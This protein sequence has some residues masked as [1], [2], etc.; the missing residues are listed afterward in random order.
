MSRDRSNGNARIVLGLTV[1]AVGVLLTLANLGLLDAGDIWQYWP[2]AL[3]LVG[4]SKLSS[5]RLWSGLVWI[6]VG[7]AFLFP[8]VFEEVEWEQV[9]NLWPLL[10]IALGLR[11]VVRSFFPE[12]RRNEAG[13]QRDEPVET[14][15]QDLNAT[16]FMTSVE[17]RV[18]GVLRHGD[19]TAVMGGCD[20]DLTR[21]EAPPEG[22]VI[23]MFA[24]W[25]G[26]TL[27]VP[28]GWEVE[29]RLAVLMG[30]IEDNTRQQP[31]TGPRLIVKG[32]ALMGGL[33]LRN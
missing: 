12:E 29:P 30:V 32:M 3:I 15:A 19:L 27:R 1:V 28:D 22:A 8:A 26:V 25:G 2:V 17:R 23:E 13:R 33:E 10:V 24:F 6:A 16:A 14:A 5:R 9:W 18:T 20:V 7:V 11:M 31:A 21:A 4:V